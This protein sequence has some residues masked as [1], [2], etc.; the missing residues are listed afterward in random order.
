MTPSVGV[1]Y[2]ILHSLHQYVIGFSFA[3]TTPREPTASPASVAITATPDEARR[4]TALHAHARKLGLC[5]G[6]KQ[7]PVAEDSRNASSM[8]VASRTART[9]LPDTTDVSATSK[10]RPRGDVHCLSTFQVCTGIHAQPHAGRPRMRAHR[11]RRT[12]GHRVRPTRRSAHPP[13]AALSFTSKPGASAETSSLSCPQSLPP[14]VRVGNE[15]HIGDRV[16]EALS[17]RAQ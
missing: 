9:V 8:T 15:G 12:G 5:G 13:S 14:P 4:T 16:C 6:W 3:S 1:W 10:R 2:E 11:T 7:R 17:R